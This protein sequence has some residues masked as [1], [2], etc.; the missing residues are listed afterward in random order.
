MKGLDQE[1]VPIVTE[2]SNEQKK[3][4]VM[5]EMA[6]Q[7]GLPIWEYNEET[8]VL[9][10]ATIKEIVVQLDTK[11][12]KSNGETKRLQIVYNSKCLYFQALNQK[13]ALR[14]LKKLGAA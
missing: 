7:K 10:K 1:P 8:K 13:N 6:S 3:H 12:D 11:K 4:R 14:K 2:I 9:K 5:A